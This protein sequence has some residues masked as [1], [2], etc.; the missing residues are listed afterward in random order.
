MLWKNKMKKI[1]FNREIRREPYGGGF[2]FIT[3]LY[4]YLKSKG[5][6]VVFSLEDNIDLIFM[7]DPR[8]SSGGDCVNSIYQYKNFNPKTK[9]IQRINDTDIA[10]PLDKP[11]RI[12][13]LLESN[14][15]AD[16]T[17][18]I[19]Q[20]VKNHYIEKGFNVQKNHSVVINGSDT[21]WYYPLSEKNFDSKKVKLI[22]HHWSDNFMKGFDVYNFLDQYVKTRKDLSFTYLGRYNKDYTP[23]N[24]KLISPMYGEEVGDVLR[25][26][27]IY[28]TAARWEACGMHHIE[29]A[30]CGLPVLYHSDGG[31]IPEVCRS[32]GLEFNNTE[33]FLLSLEEMILRYSEIRSNIDYK[34]LSIERCC[35]EYERIIK[36][37]C[38]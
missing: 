20:W 15:V 23:A 2:H 25:N 10:R 17:I 4:E 8:P 6:E 13:L 16:H 37:V 19:S 14:V 7:F 36:E 9:V 26:H 22:T 33:T 32:H 27:D 29:G 5:Y 24:T 28:V 34:Y 11:W 3:S 12:R 18:F 30:R 38:Q 1:M 31:A 21:K 35:K